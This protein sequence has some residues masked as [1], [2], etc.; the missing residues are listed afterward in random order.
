MCVCDQGQ[1]PRCMTRSYILLFDTLELFRAFA[2]VFRF[3]TQFELSVF[4]GL[5]GH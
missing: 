1:L 4:G 5:T 3:T 2:F